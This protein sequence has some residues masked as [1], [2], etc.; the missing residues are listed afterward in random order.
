MSI[1]CLAATSL[2]FDDGPT[3]VGLMMPA[4][5]AS[6]TPRS[7]L[8]SHGCTTTVVAAGIAFAAAIRRSYLEPGL[9]PPV[10][11]DAIAIPNLR[12]RGPMTLSPAVRGQDRT[13]L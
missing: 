2:I 6:A 11:L 4:S 9:I 10:S 1:P 7:E 3:R 8:S 13:I 5:A 12:C